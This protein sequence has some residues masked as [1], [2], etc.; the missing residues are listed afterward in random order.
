MRWPSG[1]GQQS[2]LLWWWGLTVR[3]GH[4]GLGGI[5][6]HVGGRRRGRGHHARVV[7]LR[8]T[9]GSTWGTGHQRRGRRRWVGHVMGHGLHLVLRRHQRRRGHTHW[10]HCPHISRSRHGHHGGRGIGKEL[11]RPVYLCEWILSR[12]HSLCSRAVSLS[13][14]VLLEGVRDADGSVAQVLSIH[15][16]NGSVAGLEAGKVHKC[17]P[18]RVT[19]VRITHD[20]RGLQNDT[21][22][23]EDIVELLL[24][25]FRIQVTNE[26]IGTH[27][28]A[29]G[30]GGCLVDAYGLAVNLDHVHDLDGEV[31]V[32]F[33]HKLHKAVT[34]VLLRDAITGHVHVHH[35]ASLQE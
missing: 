3:S 17:E 1:R 9:H 2:A 31:C 34:L 23:A 5:V 35:R 25:H 18:F 26:D 28:Q 32:V 13:L 20:L 7:M 27:I 6:P 29:L 12:K 19:S 8:R 4:E 16:F 11:M 10:C 24:L 30:I 22:G 15:G 14:G 21:K 33:S